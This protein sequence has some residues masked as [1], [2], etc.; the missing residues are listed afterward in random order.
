MNKDIINLDDD[1]QED[2][3]NYNNQTS[4]SFNNYNIKHEV[5]QEQQQVKKPLATSNSTTSSS[6]LRN[7]VANN[8]VRKTPSSSSQKAKA[9]LP[10]D[11]NRTRVFLADVHQN[12][13][14]RISEECMR[15]D[16]IQIYE[17]TKYNNYNNNYTDNNV[18]NENDNNTTMN[19]KKEKYNT[20]NNNMNI[21]NNNNSP[22]EIDD[23][24]DDDYDGYGSSST[25]TTSTTSTTNNGKQNGKGYDLDQYRDMRNQLSLLR[26]KKHQSYR[27]DKLSTKKM[28][29]MADVESL[30][31]QEEENKM[32]FAS[33]DHNSADNRRGKVN[34]INN[35]F[36]NPESIGRKAL[37][38]SNAFRAK[39]NRPPC[40]WHQGIFGI[41]VEH[42]KNM[43][44]KK[45]PFGHGGFQ[46]RIKRFPFRHI[47][48]GENVAMN[49]CD[50]TVAEVAVEGW[51]NSK[52][53]R[54]NLLADYN[55]CT[56]GVYQGSDGMWYLT[57]LFAKT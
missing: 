14:N 29:T 45:V 54:E 38:L 18:K 39:N 26:V 34:T 40:Q 4:S 25:S 57:Q 35:T 47:K 1:D 44:D 37:E 43:S 16:G 56:I 51:I 13:I 22:I 7:G 23:D 50:A 27:N 5:K 36:R 41:A 6:S 17:P 11:K 20:N 32:H 8:V 10:F 53:H 30:S 12:R 42:C 19:V 49:N 15:S 33:T 52:G 31:K 2:D 21:T 46:E 24:D 28:Y 55:I 48:S 3:N 9:I